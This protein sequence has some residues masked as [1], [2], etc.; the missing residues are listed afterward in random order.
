MVANKNIHSVVATIDL[1]SNSFHMLLAR[2]DDDKIRV[3]EQLGE[4]VQLAAGITD[5]LQL[6][7]QAMERGYNCL[8]RFA[9]FVN[10]MPLGSVRV[11]G[12]NAL[13]EARNRK[14]FIKHAEEILKHPVEIISGREEARLIYLGVSHTLRS[15]KDKRLVVDIGGGSTEFIIGQGFEPKLLESQQMGCVSYNKRFFVGEKLT[16]SRYAQAYTAARLELMAIEQSLQKMGWQEAVGSSGT[17]KAIANA[18]KSAGYSSSEADITREGI[19]WL[20]QKI[21]KL[22]DIEKL[23]IEGI[24]NDRRVILPPG[25]AILEAIFDALDIDKMTY[26]EGALREGVLYDQLGRYTHEDVRERTMTYLQERYRVDI[27]QATRVSEKALEALGQVAEAWGLEDEWYIEL[28]EWAAKVHE[29]GLDIAHYQYHKHSAYLLE[30]S[31]LLGFSKQ[32]QQELALLVRGH[33]RNI[34][35]DK[36]EEA[37]E[38]SEQLIRLCILLRFAILFHHIRSNQNKPTVKLVAKSK[39]LEIR[40]PE[41]WLEE[42]PLTR[43]DFVQEASWLKRIGYELN[44]S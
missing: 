20:K 21:L 10:D 43:A 37:A 5:N 7:D 25:L 16:A 15:S 6:D 40:F 2:V 1:G 4:K 14:V 22:G 29:I 17:I 24:K 38:N 30:Y 36:F 26:S 35:R 33:R 31:E 28:L 34:P 41:N 32:E 3:L 23:N 44:V 9:Q 42:N 13:R 18:C 8:K 12:T 39:K 11:V 27:E 19:T